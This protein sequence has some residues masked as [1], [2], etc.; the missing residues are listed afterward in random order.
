MLTW[1]IR[2]LYDVVFAV[3]FHIHVCWFPVAIQDKNIDKK[4][5]I[6]SFFKYGQRLHTVNAPQW[7]AAQVLLLHRHW[8]GSHR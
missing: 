1:H 6:L 2:M 8:S 7:Q 4:E 5:V 3:T